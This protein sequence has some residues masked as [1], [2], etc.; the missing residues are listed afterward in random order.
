MDASGLIIAKS[1]GFASITV[2]YEGW[3]NNIAVSVTSK[4]NLQVSVKDYGAV[5]NGM[6]DD[7]IAFQDAID[8]LAAKGGGDIIVPEGTYILQPIFLKSK[9][10]IIGENRDTVILKLSDE[11]PDD[12]TRLIN[13]ENVNNIK[14]QSITFDGN[15]QN[16]PNGIEHMHSI[17]VWDSEH[18]LIDNNRL[19]NAV[20]DGISISGS[21]ETSDYV[22]ISNNILKDNHRSNIVL[23]QVNHLRIFNNISTSDV[24]RPALHFEPWE[25]MSFY[26][27][28]IWNNTFTSNTE[29]YCVQLEGGQGS[30][31]FY[32]EVEFYGNTI[33]CPT[34]QFLVMETKGAK[35]HD[36][37]MNI[38]S[39]FV[40]IKNEDLNIYN[41]E[42]QSQNGITIEGTWG[43]LSKRTVISDN[44]IKTS[45]YGLHIIAGSQDTKITGNM[46]TGTGSTGVSFFA[47]ETDITNTIVSDNTFKN[48][49]YGIYTDYNYYDN[50]HIDG[51]VVQGNIFTNFSEFVL[52]I[53]GTTQNVTMNKNVVENA[54]GVYILADDRSM[55]NIK[56]TNNT[57]SSGKR[58]IV[59]QQYGSGS[60][61][62]LEIS[63]NIISNTT[64]RGDGYFTGAAIELD[65]ITIPPTN[66]SITENTLKNN[67]NN[68]ITVPDSILRACLKEML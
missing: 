41:N 16:H 10:N 50:K 32:H 57:I 46:F 9:V 7:T 48:F 58:G 62:G 26:D 34:G 13:I 52:Y 18:I 42:I 30:G 49:D 59:Q 22:M 3:T 55:S 8:G 60:L 12:Y 65:R 6:V 28:K 25:E 36:N 67:E 45:G 56:I 33:N 53:K 47:S 66:V 29:G 68:F 21:T 43:M 31:N 38:S 23:E 40:W 19:I 5:G 54:S 2:N 15:Y 51:L 27:A 14:I 63:E 24:G 4:K 20:A 64:D 44:T 11:A 39:I 1:P 17:F 37:K 35:I 61:K